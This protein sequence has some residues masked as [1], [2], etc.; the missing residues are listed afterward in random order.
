MSVKSEQILIVH[1]L[2]PRSDEMLVSRNY[3]L[4]LVAAF[5]LLLKAYDPVLSPV[6][7]ALDPW[8]WVVQTVSI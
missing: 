8:G 6:I 4:L 5:A 1:L 7:G 3:Q 2:R